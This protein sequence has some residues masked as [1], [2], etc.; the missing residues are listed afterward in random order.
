MAGEHE[1]HCRAISGELKKLRNVRSPRGTQDQSFGFGHCRT[2]SIFYSS[3]YRLGC[4][5]IR[6]AA[7]YIAY[8]RMRI[9]A[10]GCGNNRTLAGQA[11]DIIGLRLRDVKLPD[12]AS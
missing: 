8:S 7:I 3:M 4:P 6:Q 5:G 1:V 12:R 2:I 11:P 10:A 9:R